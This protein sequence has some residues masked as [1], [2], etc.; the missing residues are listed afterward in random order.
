MRKRA[1]TFLIL[2][3]VVA[4]W[5]S[6]PA[7]TLASGG[8]A[9]G[10]I[11][12]AGEARWVPSLALSSGVVL[13]TQ[14]GA[15]DS[16]LFEDMTAPPVDLRGP[17]AGDDFV[18]A[19]FFGASLEVMSPA[20]ALPGRP[21]FFLSGE[22]VPTFGS[23]RSLAFEGNPDCVRGPLPED[24]CASEEDG[25]R[26]SAYGEAEANGLG[27]RTK[28]TFG[29]MVYGALLGVAF[30]LKLGKR[31][32]RIK[33]YLAWINYKINGEGKVV[34]ATCDDPSTPLLLDE[35]TDWTE[36]TPFVGEIVHEGVMREVN[37][38]ATASQRFNGI[39]PGLDIEMDTGQFG[40][41]GSSLFVGGRAYAVLGDRAFA[42]GTSESFDDEFG[43]DTAAAAF[44][45][46]VD[47]WIFRAHA[48][49]RFQW[50]GRHK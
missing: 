40:P 50:L 47:P 18:L 32:V 27:T 19:P 22:V 31:Q 4:L 36:I 29:T 21:R 34:D 44:A 30:P 16:V 43:M 1:S 33:P 45:I 49:I 2:G 9:S 23:D 7:D 8:D 35:C 13:Q 12:Q 6:L 28:A 17:V 5:M 41:I 3:A 10:P 39:G 20:L 37:L 25:T 48:G 15:A 24:P 38:T 14:S 46:E 11:K 42:F 26:R